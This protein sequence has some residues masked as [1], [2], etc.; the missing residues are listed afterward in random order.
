MGKNMRKDIISSF[1]ILG[2]CIFFYAFTYR[3]NVI[4][5]F[6]QMAPTLWPRFNLIGIAL[7]SILIIIRSFWVRYQKTSRVEEAQ[8]TAQG[9]DS[10]INMLKSIGILFGFIFLAPYVG[11]LI[12]AFLAIAALMFLLGEQKKSVIALYSFSLVAVIYVVFGRIMS[13]PIPRGTWVFKE[14][15]Y[16]LY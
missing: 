7:F 15:S 13:V 3:I 6:E 2:V 5:G 10:I 4:V 12:T 11:F 1:C 14:I 9:N 16:W 8:G